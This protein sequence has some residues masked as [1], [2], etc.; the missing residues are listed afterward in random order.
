MP[1]KKYNVIYDPPLFVG[2]MQPDGFLDQHRESHAL[3]YY[4]LIAH[5]T[6]EE[7]V[8]DSLKLEGELE[9]QPN[10]RAIFESLATLY[11]V[12]PEAMA[13]CWDMVDMQ[14]QVLNIPT[15]PD[16]ARYRFNTPDTIILTHG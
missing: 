2:Y 10:F 4:N 9:V 16:E 15:L 13:K 12:Q 6:Y 1:D 5:N 7:H 8:R 14:C 3:F 11:G